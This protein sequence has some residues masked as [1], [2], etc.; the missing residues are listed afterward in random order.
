MS[1]ELRIDPGKCIRCGACVTFAPEI[2][3]IESRGPARV[4]RQPATPLE[5][6]RARAALLNC[7]TDAVTR[8]VLA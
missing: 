5:E 3:T 2:F 7:P 1:D 4:L 6:R 8:L